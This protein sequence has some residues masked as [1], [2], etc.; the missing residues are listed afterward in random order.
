MNVSIKLEVDIQ[1]ENRNVTGKLN[2][3]FDDLTKA[4]QWLEKM[5]QLNEQ[6]IFEA[7]PR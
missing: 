5:N 2:A 1:D 7:I 3:S 4:S 6:G